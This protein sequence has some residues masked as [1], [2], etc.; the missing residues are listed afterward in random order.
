MF[1]VMMPEFSRIVTKPGFMTHTV[2]D[3]MN[4]AMKK[5]KAKLSMKPIA[6]CSVLVHQTKSP[7]VLGIVMERLMNVRERRKTTGR[8]RITERGRLSPGNR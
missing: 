8:A 2:S 3:P 7:P 6:G 1:P 5:V 4:E